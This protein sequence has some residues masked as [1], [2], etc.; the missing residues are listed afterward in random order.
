MANKDPNEPIQNIKEGDEEEDFK[1]QG[2]QA[3]QL[4]P[5]EACAQAIQAQAIQAQE[6]QAK[7]AVR[8]PGIGHPLT[9]VMAA[10]NQ[11]ARQRM[12]PKI[13]ANRYRQVS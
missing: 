11:M 1:A 10:N 13:F 9:H 2:Y 5:S 4:T 6:D 7:A 3:R 8:G 12:L